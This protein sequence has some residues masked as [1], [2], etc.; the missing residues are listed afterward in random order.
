MPAPA[1]PPIPVEQAHICKPKAAITV[2]TNDERAS[3]LLHGEINCIH[4]FFAS[5]SSPGTSR[6]VAPGDCVFLATDEPCSQCLSGI[7]CAGFDNFFHLFTHEDSRDLFAVPHDIRILEE[8]FRVHV[9]E[10]V[11]ENDAALARRPL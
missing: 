8:V 5:S 1:N 9:A 4:Q 7:A 3:P 2:A 11:G 6:P 10:G